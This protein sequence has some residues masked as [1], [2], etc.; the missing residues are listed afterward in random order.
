MTLLEER[1]ERQV[2]DNNKQTIIIDVSTMPAWLAME[3]IGIVKDV[4]GVLTEQ[5]YEVQYTKRSAPQK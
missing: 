3:T 1:L 5:G 4:C 2:Q